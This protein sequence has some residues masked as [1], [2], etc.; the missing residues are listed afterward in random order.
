MELNLPFIN[1]FQFL[2][3][4]LSVQSSFKKHFRAGLYS[5][6]N[7]KEGTML[8]FKLYPCVH[9]LPQ[10]ELICQS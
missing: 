9:H 5:Y 2:Y 7:W 1:T 6:Q 8:L 10:S 3:Y 4:Y